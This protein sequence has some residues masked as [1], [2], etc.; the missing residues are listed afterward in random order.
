[1]IGRYL[2]PAPLGLRN[3]ADQQLNIPRLRRFDGKEYVLPS[4]EAAV[5]ENWLGKW[6][7]NQM[8]DQRL[9]PQ[10]CAFGSAP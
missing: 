6:A 5:A 1:V 3:N 8:L 9:D 2:S 4:W 10:V 7:M